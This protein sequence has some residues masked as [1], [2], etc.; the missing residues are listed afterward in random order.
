MRTGAR[1]PPV[2]GRPRE[3]RDLRLDARQRRRTV[4]AAVL[5]ALLGAA[6]GLAFLFL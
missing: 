3:P 5:A 4:L 1:R 2:P 6:I